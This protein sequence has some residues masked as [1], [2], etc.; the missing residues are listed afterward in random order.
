MNTNTHPFLQPATTAG[1]TISFYSDDINIYI[2]ATSSGGGG[3][4]GGSNTQVQFNDS[5]AFGGDAG[6]T[7]N[8]NTDSAFLAGNMS[9][10]GFIAT[11]ETASRVAIFDSGKKITS[12]DTTIYPSLAELAYLKG[13][14]G[15]MP[16]IIYKD[17]TS[18]SLTGTTAQTIMA[19]FLV[20]ANTFQVADILQYRINWRKVGT[21][22]NGTL[23]VLV[24]TSVSLVGAT[25]L[26][27]RTMGS[28]NAW[29]QTKRTIVFK[30]SL[31]AQRTFPVANTTT[32]NDDT[33]T[34]NESAL[35]ID[36]TADQYFLIALT[37][38][39]AADTHTIES[40]IF[41]VKR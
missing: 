20:P 15:K 32:D 27:T 37:N 17:N 3:T 24:N 36:F 18:Y 10:S 35:T 13:V 7:Y 8:K 39:N 19:S 22:G 26:M 14:V 1:N 31:A 12:A 34:G 41:V 29:A 25:G 28:A 38:A 21:A 4:P 23:N 33:A 11:G 5:S 6:F 30:N 2:A 9:A 16:S 40:S